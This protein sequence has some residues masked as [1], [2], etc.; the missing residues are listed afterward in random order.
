MTLFW[1]KTWQLGLK[2]LWL[3]PLRS[4][5]TVLGIFI[6]VSSVIW[7]LA[8]GEGIS[9]KAQ[10][11]IESLGADNI[12]VR[13]IRPPAEALSGSGNA[14]LPYGLKWSDHDRLVDTVATIRQVLP[15]REIRRQ[16]RSESRRIDGRLVGCTPEYAALARLELDQGRFLTDIDMHA[17]KN[18]CVLS[19][20]VAE[21]LFPLEDPLGQTIQHD[22]N[23]GTNYYIVVGVMKPRGATAAIGGSLAAQ[24]YSHDVYVSIT[25]LWERVGD[26]VVTRGS[27]SFQAEIVELSQ[28][29]LRIDDVDH[30]VRTAQVVEN[31]LRAYRKAD[32]IDYAVVVP[33]ELLEQARTTRLM[34]ISLMGM[35]A[36][37]SL[38]VGGI[39]IMNIMLATVT[40]RTREIGIRRALGA[41][42][43]DVTRQFLAETV[44]LSVVGGLTGILGGFTCRPLVD[45]VRGRL[46]AWLP[47]MMG[48]LPEVVSTVSPVIVPW[49]IP[50]AFGISVAVGV[51]FG[52]YPAMRAARM[53]PI[54]ALRHE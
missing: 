29:T 23:E 11:Q 38:V 41:K 12:I 50:L 19:A 17:K 47:E 22:T 5:L 40:E 45:F 2:S 52:L 16:F 7:L 20:K 14:P 35:I 44:A 31:T 9:Q 21:A 26:F 46:T 28:M 54:E 30:V 34:F 6:G 49:S 4:L 13:T 8:I 3:H 33:L 10:Q 51:V 42:K 15:I 1:W 53:D 36:A 25:S 48:E 43:G 27:G 18:H 24:D 32:S 37:I 39:G